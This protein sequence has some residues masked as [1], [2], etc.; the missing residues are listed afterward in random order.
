[1]PTDPEPLRNDG[2]QLRAVTAQMLA[3]QAV[4]CRS[5]RSELYARLLSAAAED[6]TAGG[7]T[8]QVLQTV[9]TTDW[10]AALALRFM[11]AVHR[12]VLEGRAPR[13][14]T[15]FPSA[16]GGDTG[17]PWPALRELL[18]EHPAEVLR[19]TAQQCQTN[20]V[21]RSRALLVGFLTVASETGLGLRLLEVGASAG[22]NLRWDHYFTAATGGSPS[23]GPH[24]SP[25][26]MVGAWDVEP[27]L[28]PVVPR[29]VE[30]RGCDPNPLDP[31]TDDGAM[32]L[33]S[34][35]WGDQVDRLQRLRGAI[36]VAR[37]VP[38]T[39][40]GA[41]AG[42]WVAQHVAEPTEGAATVIFHSVVWQYLSLQDRREMTG[43]IEAAGA[44]ATVNA[45]VA[46]LSME[47][48][49]P[50]RIRWYDIRLRLW[51]A[52][53]DRVVATAGAHGFPVR[54]P[55]QPQEHAT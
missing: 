52:G 50:G 54:R 14:A 48:D 55:D 9:A 51:P 17:D 5:L 40:D 19:L 36:E 43:A 12:L 42:R 31:L 32:R 7:V 20:E 16:G 22:L 3:E 21:G 2:D 29:V 38:A 45:P 34:A 30:R 6:C 37:R 25:V 35:V 46:W 24:D 39:V 27:G 33:A 49:D 4:H 47:P 13:L 44:K 23:W 1:M 11:A 41:P 26:Q 18:A 28:R 53:T 10:Q 8:W 15:H